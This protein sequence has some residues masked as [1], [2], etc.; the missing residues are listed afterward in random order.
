MRVIYSYKLHIHIF[1]LSSAFFCFAIFLQHFLIT[2][3]L[4]IGNRKIGN[5]EI[6]KWDFGNLVNIK[7]LS[8]FFA[9]IQGIG[10]NEE[11]SEEIE[12]KK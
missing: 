2:N 8:D 1:N 3:F 12:N 9:T 10:E 6:G 7:E 11:R 5:G 4:E